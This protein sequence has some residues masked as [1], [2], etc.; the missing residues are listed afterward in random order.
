MLFP[1]VTI[2]GR[3][4]MDGGIL[5]HL[6]AAAAPPTDVLAVL[7]CHSLGSKGAGV[8]GSLAASVTSDRHRRQHR[9]SR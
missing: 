8:G 6:N 4:Y 9:R 3:R 2:K 7:S 1:T 5:S